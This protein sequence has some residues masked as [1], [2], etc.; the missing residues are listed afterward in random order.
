MWRNVPPNRTCPSSISSL[1]PRAA[2]ILP[3][4]SF[5]PA[6]MGVFLVKSFFVFFVVRR[7][8]IGHWF[9]L[10]KR[11]L[12]VSVSLARVDILPFA[13]GGENGE[14]ET[15]VRDAEHRRSRRARSACP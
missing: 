7:D 9:H 1:T 4:A 15:G 3:T 12:D 13:V 5:N 8:P 2:C 11:G 6:H 10:G 14:R